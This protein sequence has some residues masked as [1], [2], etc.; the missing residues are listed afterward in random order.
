METLLFIFGVCG[1]SIVTGLV[2]QRELAKSQKRFREQRQSAFLIHAVQN[3]GGL[4]HTTTQNDRPRELSVRCAIQGEPLP[5][6]LSQ[7]VS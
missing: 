6:N 4:H 2:C 7:M 1:I 5:L 3:M